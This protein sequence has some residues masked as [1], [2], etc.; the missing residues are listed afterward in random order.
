MAQEMIRLS[1]GAQI[2]ASV[3]GSG[4]DLLLVSGLGGTA[5]FWEPIA[6]LLHPHFRVIRFDQRG[7]GASARGTGAVTIARLAGDTL[8]VLEHFESREALLLGHSTGG[9]IVQELALRDA[10]RAAGLILSATWG[11]PSR[12]MQELFRARLGLLATHPREYAAFGAFLGYTPDW[13]DANWP[14]YAAL[15]DAAPTEAAKQAVV[16]ERIAALLAFDRSAEI[17]RIKLPTLIQ[18]AEDDLIVPAFLQRELAGLMPGARLDM[19][20]CGG[21]FFPLTRSTQVVKALL[22]WQREYC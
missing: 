14:S 18:G 4:R 7:L 2:A 9:A 22:D 17:S 11:R 3:G 6:P 21:H 19:L 1:D 15:L 12:Y 20:A 16:A 10:S 13:L 5:A 8:A